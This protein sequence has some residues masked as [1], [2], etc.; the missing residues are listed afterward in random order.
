MTPTRAPCVTSWPPTR[1]REAAAPPA[2]SSAG[3]D[4][5]VGSWSSSLVTRTWVSA[6]LRR[7]LSRWRWLDEPIAERAYRRRDRRIGVAQLGAESRQV[8]LDPQRVGVGLPAPPG[9]EQLLVCD[10]VAA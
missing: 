2:S 9:L 1:R 5:A 7:R 10:E 8:R 3:T 6:R 4:G